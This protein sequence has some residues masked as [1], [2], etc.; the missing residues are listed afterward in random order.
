VDNRGVPRDLTDYRRKRDAARTPEPVPEPEPAPKRRSRRR[1]STGDTFV[2][3]EHH[4][5]AL[6]WDFRLERDGVLVSW[7][8]PKGLP[9]DPKTNHLAVPTEDHPLEYADFAGDIPAGEYGG[10]SVSIWDEGT[11]ETEKWT[12]REV[13]VV[14]HGRRVQGRYV[15]FRT[16]DK[17]W[18][19]HRLDPPEEGSEPMPEHIAPM[20]AVLGSLPRPEEEDRWGYE[21][22]WDGVRA[23][24]YVDGGRIRLLTR[25][26][27]DVTRTYP[28]IR[29]LGEFLGS[30]RAVLDGE[31]VALDD[32]GRPSFETLQRRMHVTG[33]SQVRR[34]VQSVPVTYLLFDVMYVDGQSTVDRPYEERRE[35]LAGLKLDGAH[36]QT[37]D[38]FVGGGTEVLRASRE[39]G[40]EGIVAKRLGS[41]YRPGRRTGDWVKVKHERHQEVVI[42]GWRPGQ[43]RRAGR[44]GSLLLGVQTDDGLRYAGQVGT[45][46]TDAT[47]EDLG[48]RL[49]RL[50]RKTSPFVDEVPRAQARDAHW[51]SPRLVGEVQYAEWT[52]DGRLRHPS[53]R[54]LR[55]DKEPQSVR[56]EE[57]PGG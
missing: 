11:Y 57:P 56:R 9:T 13:K 4:A 26:D 37:P 43:G 51:I 52:R 47:L 46:F 25:N 32:K 18:M 20:L 5:R 10:G 8:V 50:E 42:G 33:E 41:A 55:P 35:R 16:G 28:E 30:T 38:Y 49:A 48:R 36:W 3:Q 29:G 44:I 23:V 53:W 19:I 45:G 7:A 34:L 39:Q 15:L 14:L 21:F 12:D 1:R 27:H 40:L 17:R 31:I 6:H 22:K 2:V 54:G 24:C